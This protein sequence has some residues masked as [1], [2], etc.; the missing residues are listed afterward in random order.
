[1]D[2]SDQILRQTIVGI[3]YGSKYAGTTVLCYNSAHKVRFIEAS[4]N[5]D[6]DSFL[7]A[8]LAFLQPELVMIDA[9]LSLPGVYWL[10]NGYHDHFFRKC[11]RDV[12]A[13]S[14]MF[15]GG[16]TARA[17][18]LQKY[19][20]GMRIRMIETYPRRLAEVLELPMDLYKKDKNTL[21][22]FVEK[23]IRKIGVRINAER[24]SSWH[25]LD[26]LLAFI[27]GLRYG[28]HQILEYGSKEEGLI[29]V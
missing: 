20:N 18:N 26:A 24:V 5:A 7:L 10:G 23:L 8:E 28:E 17:M 11:D 29:L 4:R 27:S 14:P 21:P 1:M 2:R 12:H 19:L 9:P 15:L 3:D 16:L 22:E 25:H 6:A 13:M